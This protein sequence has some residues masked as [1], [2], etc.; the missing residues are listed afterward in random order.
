MRTSIVGLVLSLLA[1]H[2][3]HAF[4]IDGLSSGMSMEKAKK[5]LEASSS[6]KNI[7]VK[8]TGIIAYG[9]NRFILLN[10]CKD[11]LVL[12]QKHLTPGFDH[13]VRLIDEKTRELGKPSDA[14][15]EPVDVNVP[16][17]RNAVSFLWRGDVTSVKVTYTEFA[18]NKQLD[19]LY[20]NRNAC[21]QV[22]H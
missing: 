7:Q 10:F 16:V 8:E 20:E 13:F 21:R 22:L 15:T 18:S 9:G 19:E 3:S 14:W 11:E 12:A 1:A 5:I 17:E 6:Y 4:E 2:G